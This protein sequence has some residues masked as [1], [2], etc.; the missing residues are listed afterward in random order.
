M[1]FVTMMPSLEVTVQHLKDFLPGDAS[2]NA[3]PEQ[4][5]ELF[6]SALHLLSELK[7]CQ[8]TIHASGYVDEF[9]KIAEISHF[10][11]L[12]FPVFLPETMLHI[13]RPTKYQPSMQ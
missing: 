12:I 2:N 13:L 11:L 7:T 1:T 5:A 6:L 3:S 9:A 4:M 8:Y 10:F